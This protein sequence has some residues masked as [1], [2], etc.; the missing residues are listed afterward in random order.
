MQW[1]WIT[2][3]SYR[4]RQGEFASRTGEDFGAFFIPGPCGRDL[5]VLASS[6]GEGVEWEHVSVSLTNRCPNWQEMCFI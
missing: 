2:L 1:E 5:K 3:E 4:V 6:G